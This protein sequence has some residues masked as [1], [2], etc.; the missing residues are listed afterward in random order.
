V[1]SRD[2]VDD[3]Q[4]E[5]DASA[6]SRLVGAREPLERARQELCVEPISLVRN[7][8]LDL[9]AVR[10]GEERDRPITVAKRVLDQVAEC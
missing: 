4:S 5:P 2:H 10:S 1:C 8:E 3:R 6:T 7:V 9:A